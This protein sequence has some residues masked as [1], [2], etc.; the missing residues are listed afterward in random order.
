MARTVATATAQDATTA[1]PDLPPGH[2]LVFGV[3]VAR[4]E[5]DGLVAG[6]AG[7]VSTA[8]DMARWLVAQSTGGGPVLSPESV[9]LMQ[10]PP[11]G[12][13]GGYGM[14]WQVVTPEDGPRRIEH[15]G[16]LSTY[17]ADQVLLP[18]SG[19][20]FALLYNANSTFVDTPGL[21]AGFAALLSGDSSPG[22]P[23][24]ASVLA[25]VLGAATL[26][27]LAL[28]VRLLL[29]IPRWRRRRAGRRW[30][31]ALPGLVWPVLPVGLLAALPALVRLAAGRSFTF[32]QL[33]LAMPDQVILLAVAALTGTAVAAT[34]VVALARSD[35]DG[36]TT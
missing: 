14:G 28:R 1:A 34:R 33:S 8:E 15:H 17:S 4:P 5:L 16:V 21:K 19:Y 36:E 35:P 32:W 9:A 23:R 7:A 27:V 20:G 26:A 30:W 18:D 25:G 10:T 29:R 24:S 6:S 22:G 3:P 31:T 13:A 2:I 12:V 11:A